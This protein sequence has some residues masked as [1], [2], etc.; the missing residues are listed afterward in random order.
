MSRIPKLLIG[1]G[2]LL[3]AIP[4]HASADDLPIL[5]LTDTIVSLGEV[6]SENDKGITNRYVVRARGR[7]AGKTSASD[8]MKIEWKA[9]GKVVSE[10]ECEVNGGSFE[11]TGDDAKPLDHYGALQAVFSYVDDSEDTTSPIYTMNLRVGRFWNWYQ[12][13]KKTLHY[14][15]YQLDH[16]DLQGSAVVRHE[17]SGYYQTEAG[18]LT[19][20]TYMA[21]GNE[22]WSGRG[23]TIRC[24]VGGKK[25]IDG[26]ASPGDLLIAETIDWRGPDADKHEVKFVRVSFQAAGYLWGTRD[27]IGEE[28]VKTSI[29]AGETVLLGEHPGEWSC[30]WRQR[31]KVLRNFTFTVG[32]DGRIAPHREQ[33]TGLRLPPGDVAVG[34]SFPDEVLDAYF[35]PAA[36]KAGGFFGRPWSDPAT[37]ATIKVGKAKGSIELSPPKGAKGGT[38]VK[39][40]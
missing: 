18:G 21:A 2:A 29:E 30:D 28:H 22:G 39:V 31:G 8:R 36:V 27:K 5:S 33:T 1:A 34:V 10:I 35:D 17:P 12:R 7:L 24:S 16:S 19:F 11:C 37:V 40:K 32:T 6:R 4:A 25:L 13:G 26:G 23:E 15:K 9:G 14:P 3:A 20:Y 38:A